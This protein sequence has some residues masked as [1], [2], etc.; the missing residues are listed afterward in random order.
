MD[1]T[2]SALE[3]PI[4]AHIDSCMPHVALDVDS[5]P[6]FAVDADAAVLHEIEARSHDCFPVVCVPLS[7]LMNAPQ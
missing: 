3:R 4:V 7:K 6:A 5:D 2:P 1:D